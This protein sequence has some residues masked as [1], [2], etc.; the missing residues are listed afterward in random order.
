[1]NVTVGAKTDVG[2]VRQANEDS[3]L[4]HEPLFVVADGMGGHIAGDVASSTAVSVIS[5]N[6]TT[7]SAE[8]LETLAELV[9]A[10]NKAIWEK[11]GEDPNLRGMGTTCTLMLIDN[12]K[13]HFAHVGDSRAYLMRNGQLSQ[14]TEDHTLV[15]RMVKEGKLKP[16]EAENHPQRSIITRALGVDADVEVDLLSLDLAVGDRIILNSDGLSSMISDDEIANAVR[17]EA[18]PQAASERLVELANH[19]GGEDNVTVVVVDITDQRPAAA[20]AISRSPTV[21]AQAPTQGDGVASSPQGGGAAAAPAA[22]MSTRRTWPRKLILGVAVLAILLVGG[23]F[24]FKWYLDQQFFVGLNEDDVVTIFQGV[25]GS[26]LGMELSSEVSVSDPPIG[27][28]DL[29]ETQQDTVTDG[30]EADSEEAARDE[31][32][33]LREAAKSKGDFEEPQDNLGSGGG[34]GDGDK[35]SEKRSEEKAEDSN[36]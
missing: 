4:V 24:A 25:E 6:A 2:Q 36:Q 22:E 34:A 29:P 35:A 30:L 15:G 8:N 3:Y 17:E 18:D 12:T 26:F 16:E 33:K 31:V 27:L 11:A 28:S 23:F 10:A 19:A 7:A 21:E 1:M 32:A 14:I 13:A 9:R 5:G 20:T